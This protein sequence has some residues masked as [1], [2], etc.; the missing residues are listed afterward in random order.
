MSKKGELIKLDIT[1]DQYIKI[2]LESALEK[3]RGR[4][5]YKY[6]K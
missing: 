3:Y 1:G 5:V 4:F 6:G 2:D